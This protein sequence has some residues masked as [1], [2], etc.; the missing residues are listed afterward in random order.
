MSV[1]LTILVSVFLFGVIIFVH[2]LGHFITAKLSGITVKEFALGMGPVIFKKIKNNTQYALRL[3]PIGGFVSMVGEDEESDE[4]GSFGKAPVGN[5]ILVVVSGA[6]MNL[7]LGFLIVVGLTTFSKGDLITTSTIAEFKAGAVTKAS[8]LREGDT[9]VSINGRNMFVAND[10][11][12]ELTRVKGNEAEV[13]VERD[14]EKVKL[15]AVEF[16][17]KEGKDGINE[18]NIDFYMYGREKTVF[19]VIKESGLWTL[20]ITRLVFVSLFDL[21]TGNVPINQLSGPIGIVQ[22][23]G[24][25]VSVDFYAVFYLAAIITIN[26]GVMN[27]LPLPALDG[28]RFVILLIEAITKRRLNPKYEGYIHLV[29]FVLLIALMLFVTYNDI[30]KIFSR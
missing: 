21:I 17:I 12:Y 2:E 6:I 30:S 16:D 9:I 23:I 15:E 18:I 7:V 4:E 20:S 26:L 22:L 27:I 28:G 11:I 19:N 24:E 25:A 14:G 29:G 3:F 8:G 1:V 5:R 13:T 10:I